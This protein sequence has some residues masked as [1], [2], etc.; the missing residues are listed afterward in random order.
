MDGPRDTMLNE[1]S[2]RRR[3]ILHYFTYMWNLKNK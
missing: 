1:M 3:Q 2:D